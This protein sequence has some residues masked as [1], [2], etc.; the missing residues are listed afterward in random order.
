MTEAAVLGFGTVGSGVVEVI[1][2]NQAAIRVQ[3]PEGIHVK[4]ILDLRSFPDSP[5][6]DKVVHDINVIREDPEIRIVCETMGGM[7][8]AFSF[9]KSFLEKGVSVC[10]SN[11]EL[12]A[13]HGP[14]L[15][16]LAKANRCSYLFEASVGGGIPLLRTIES[17]LVQ[18]RITA[19]YGILNGT[20]NYILTKMAREG[21]DFDATL[22]EA[23]DK[24]YAERNPESDIEGHDT[25]RKIAILTSLVSGSTFRYEDVYCEGITKITAADFKYAKTLGMSVKLLGVSRRDPET[26]EFHVL[27]APFLVSCEHP[28]Y[29]VNDV[30]NG[31]FIHGNMVDD[32]MLYGRGAGK[33]PTASAVVS[34]VIDCAS[35]DGRW[36]TR[37]WDPEVIEPGDRLSEV[38]RFF[39]RT[40]ADSEEA[41]RKAFPGLTV[42]TADGM[43]GEFA[44]VTDRVTEGE[45]EGKAAGLKLRN[46]IRFLN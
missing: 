45:F 22:K 11:K 2:R 41:A 38:R 15:I 26:L 20:T 24:G 39:V 42:V 30:F 35:H 21:A 16:A 7:E 17:S 37:R 1:D 32:L 34:D 36:I 8:P 9:T 5:Y 13:A 33:Y 23:Q 6:A 43:E 28:L 18:E 46:R 4:Y 3:F 19:V 25:A 14:E 29:S 40:D 12:V 31:V 10:T 27:T 44:F